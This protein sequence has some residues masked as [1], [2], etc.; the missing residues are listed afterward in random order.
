MPV[1]RQRLLCCHVPNFLSDAQTRTVRST[2]SKLPQ[3]IRNHTEEGMFFAATH[4]GHEV[5][6]ALAVPR[7]SFGIQLE[8]PQDLGFVGRSMVRR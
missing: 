5:A 2:C 3:I 7:P 4:S 1:G 6:L 8:A